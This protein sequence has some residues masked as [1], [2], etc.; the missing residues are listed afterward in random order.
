MKIGSA[1]QPNRSLGLQASG[2]CVSRLTAIV[3]LLYLTV[4]GIKFYLA[5]RLDLHSDEAFYWLESQHLAISYSDVPFLTPLLIKA[6]TLVA[7]ATTLGVRL[8]F[9]IL[10]ALLPFAVYF[11]AQ[12]VVGAFNAKISVFFFLLMPMLSTL[13]L[14]AVP[15]VPLVFLEVICL[16]D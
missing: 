11:V 16:V 9:L 3:A 15:D 2:L 1:D 7:G 14:V 4:Q 6:G 10:G 8:P 12:P 13:G 5:V